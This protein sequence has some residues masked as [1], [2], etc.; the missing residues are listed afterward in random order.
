MP[1]AN[2]RVKGFICLTHCDYNSPL[3][4]ANT[5]TQ[6]E[7]GPGGGSEAQTSEEHCLQASLMEALFLALRVP[8]PR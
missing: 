8:L 7:Q 5:G 3:R 6:V 4:G 1:E 2:S